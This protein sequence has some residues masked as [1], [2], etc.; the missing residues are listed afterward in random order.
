M[1]QAYMGSRK[2]QDILSKMGTWG[3]WERVE[4][5]GRDREESREKIRTQ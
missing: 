3:P 5:E 1:G 2:S 4:G